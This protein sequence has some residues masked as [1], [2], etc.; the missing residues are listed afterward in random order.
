[1]PK[2]FQVPMIRLKLAD[3]FLHA[4]E[5]VAGDVNS[6]LAPHGLTR[7]SFSDPDLLVPAPTMYDVV[8]QLGE[9]SGDPYIGI[10]LGEKLDPLSWSPLI[11]AAAQGRTLGDLLLRFSIDAHKDASS[12]EYALETRSNRCTFA[13]RRGA[14]FGRTPR[15]NDAFGAAFVLAILRAA[16]GK[17]WRGADVLVHTCDPSV[18]P[19]G[20]LNV[21]LAKGDSLGFRVAFPCE[22]LLLE[23]VLA[24]KHFQANTAAAATIPSDSLP[25]LRHV[26]SRHLHETGLDAQRVAELCGFSKRTLARRLSEHNTTLKA[27]LDALRLARA[28]TALLVEGCSVA[29]VGASVGYPEPSVFTRVFRRWTG[30][31]PRQF[32]DQGKHQSA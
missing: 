17:E 9:A 7:D 5:A 24:Q 11:E 23:P 21:R 8:E 4:A 30:R 15:H 6:V 2:S 12:V 1:M 32:R 25:A 16:T 31:T 18:I 19:P 22:W 3:N 29:Q 27:E 28:K 10:H 20:Y 26:L 14:D 13:E